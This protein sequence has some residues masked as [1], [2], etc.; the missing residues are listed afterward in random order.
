MSTVYTKH[1]AIG[2]AVERAMKDADTY[3]VYQHDSGEP[4]YIIKAASVPVP[5]GFK[6]VFTAEGNAS[7]KATVYAS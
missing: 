6:R 5:R 7:D 3:C 4:D 1:H 2:R